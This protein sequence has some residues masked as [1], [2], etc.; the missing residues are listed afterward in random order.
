MSDRGSL[1]ARVPHTT[2]GAT[3]RKLIAVSPVTVVEARGE[4][5]RI[6]ARRHMPAG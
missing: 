4:L 1:R 3:V 5:Q 2:S 6:G